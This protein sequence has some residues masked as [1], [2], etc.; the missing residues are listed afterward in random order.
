MKNYH[1]DEIFKV[2]K[3]ELSKYKTPIAT[4]IASKTR[5]PFLVLISCLLSLRTR[6]QVTEVAS[7][8]LFQVAKTPQEILKLPT[9]RIEKL[10]Y[11]V[12]FYKT[13]AKR[14]KEICKTLIKDYNSKVP[15]T[16]EELLKLKGVGRKT[17]NIVLVYAYNKPALPIDIHCFRLPNRIGWIKTKNPKE[18][19]F[20]LSKI[21]PK[22]YWHDFN[23]LFVTFGQNICKP[24]RPLCGICPIS[25][26]CNYYEN[27]YLKNFNEEVLETIKKF[28]KI[29]PKFPDGRINY[30]N[31]NI[32]PVLTVYIKH[33]NKILLLKRSNKVRTYQGKWNTVA[34]YLD[35]LK[36]L[37]EKVLEELREEIGIREDNLLSIKFLNRYKFTDPSIKKTW[38]TYPVI[39]EIKNPKI[40]LDWEHT[41]H[42]W[43]KLE[44]VRKFDTVP[45]LGKVLEK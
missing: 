16:E 29:L 4:E 33:K 23:D 38:I 10:I 42:K 9:K 35:E 7:K 32:A 43:I 37:R 3:K 18:T 26:Y 19:E 1:F 24:V 27:V 12:G 11:P 45:N 30:R 20:A 6:D 13:K 21:I 22:K 31:S 40:K 8:K 25:E 2:L 14:I 15:E 44:D 34:G 41:E 28:Y 17:A 39:V 5:D 36:S